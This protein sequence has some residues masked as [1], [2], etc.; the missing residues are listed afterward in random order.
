MDIT[1]LVSV[2]PGVGP[3]RAENLQELGIATIEDL[4]TYYPFRYD[5]IQEKDLSEIQDQEKVTLKGLVVSE[6]VVSRYGYKK[7]RLTFRM[8]Q[9]HAVINVSFFNQPFLKDKVVLSEE[10]A[11]YGKWD[12]KRK[13]LN[14]MKI[15]ASKGDNEDF[16][17]IY[18]VNKKVRQSTLVQLIR[19]AFEEYGSL[20]EEI[21]PNDLLEKYRLMPRKE[22]MWAMHFPSNPEESHQAKRRVVFEE[23]FLFQ[24]KMQGLKKQEKAEKNGLAVQ[25]DVDRLKTFTQGLPFELTGAQKKVTN[26]ICRDLR[27]PKHMQRL[28]QGDVGSGKTVVAAIALYATMTAGFQGALMVPT[29]ILAQ[30]HMESLQQ[31]F[32]PLEVR[33]A[34]LTGSTKTK[35]RRLILEELANGEIDI[36]VGT[37]ALIQQDVS[38]HQLGL[39][40]TDE[41]HRFGVNQRKI[42]REKGLKPDVLF[43]TATPIPRTLALTVYG[44]MTVSEIHHMPAG[45]KPIIS[46]W[47]TSSQMKDVYQKMQEQLAQ[48]FQIYAVTPLITESETLDLKNAEEL[49]AKLSHD[50]SNQNVVLLH[51]QMPGPKKDEIM[52][53]FASGKI[54]ILVTTS[55]I[56]V[57]VDV[58]NANMMVI[59]NADRFGLSQLHQLRG[60]IGRG[61][62]QSY[63]VFIADPKTDSGKARMKII[64]ATNDGF[65]L[66]EEDLKMRGEGDL[67]GKAQSGLP[68]FRVGDVVNNYNTLVVAQKVARE[69]V[70]QD[71]KL[72]DHQTLNQ[73]LEYKQLEQNRI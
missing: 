36:V 50:F 44:D 64:A 35:E 55:V 67:F 4:L 32:D 12:A 7:S 63:C 56:E 37:H 26:E 28:L 40:I 14:G 6:A 43:M 59:Y 17:P 1:D 25:Y 11:V 15:L 72:A 69:L 29:E 46:S 54:N 70:Q 8:M 47:K 24:L 10:I 39:V 52:T 61:K 65:K 51:G 60:R 53:A 68:E 30:Q 45:R 49:H 2:L 13:S 58:A 48:G 62:T 42:L 16:A 34:L 19:T 22:A 5:D 3:K 23:F 27:S 33:T 41:Q 31:L 9:E 66:A 71:P 57:G 21:L 20:I 73:V 38:F 18:H